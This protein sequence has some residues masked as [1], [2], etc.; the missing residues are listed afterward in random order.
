MNI[1]A[2]NIARA[3]LTASEAATFLS[4][5]AATAIKGKAQIDEGKAKGAAAL[6]IM[7]AGFASDEIAVLD[8]SFEIKA[9]DGAIHYHVDCMGLAEFGRDDLD[10]SRNGEG[11]V[12]R[13]AQGAYKAGFLAAMFNVTEKN[14]GLWTMANKAVAM[15]Q[16]IRAENMTATIENG[17]LVLTGG[18]GDKAEAMK[19]AKSLAAL[20]KVA[21]DETGTTRAA[22]SN[23]KGEGEAR[24]ATPAEIMALAARLVEGVT[25]GEEALSNTA[26]SFARKIAALVA[27]NPEAFAEA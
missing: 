15:A 26:L 11:K 23:A 7:T 10:W 8:W 24:V 14:D 25:K 20:T 18:T 9:K 5:A 6:A 1:T 12:S 13:E 17:V 3:S 16:A 27:S 21:K 22:P 2:N 19:S 4:V